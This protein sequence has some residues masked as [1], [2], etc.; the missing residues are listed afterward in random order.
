[1]GLKWRGLLSILFIAAFV[2]SFI[3][4]L[5]LIEEDKNNAY[6]SGLMFLTI[7]FCF[8]GAGSAVTYYMIKIRELKRR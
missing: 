6:V 8:M 2:V 7:V 3:L 4:L 1:M 5:Y